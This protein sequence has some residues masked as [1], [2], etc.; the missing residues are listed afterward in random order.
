MQF[1]LTPVVKRLLI[2]CFAMFLVQQT[3]DQ[4]FGGNVTESL[5]LVP[6]AFIFEFRFW[7]IFTYPFLH[8]DVTHLLLNL[9]VLAFIGGELEAAWGRGRFLRYYFTCSTVACVFYLVLQMWG[10]K[11]TG[12]QTPMIGASGAIYGL[13]TAY[14]LIFGERVMLFM[15]LF[16]MK[17]KHFVLVLGGVE[18]MTSLFSGRSGLSSAA[19][20]GGMIAGFAVLFGRASWI[21][22]RR[23]REERA[24]QN[25]RVARM[26][27]KHLKLVIDN[28]GGTP[29]K[30][31]GK[32]KS[33]KPTW[34]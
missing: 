26:K 27:N 6:A 31:D 17:A 20:L 7:Q 22:Y 2:A 28:D 5:G 13:L 11:G 23:K 32:D 21:V 18:L 24:Q 4:F 9:L 34:H 29:P 33:K 16:P 14:G 30:K 8:A 15:M 12:L 3:T 10:W 25:T 19:H 1:R